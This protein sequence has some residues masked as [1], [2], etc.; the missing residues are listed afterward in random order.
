MSLVFSDDAPPPTPLNESIEDTYI[1]QTSAP[2]NVVVHKDNSRILGM[3]VEG[4][5]LHVLKAIEV[6][7]N[8]TT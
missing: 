7:I 1:T 6:S 8:R 5:V 4:A 3:S 2:P